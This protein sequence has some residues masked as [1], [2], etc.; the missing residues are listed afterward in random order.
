[1]KHGTQ[2]RFTKLKGVLVNNLLKEYNKQTKQEGDQVVY[3]H[4]VMEVEKILA[5]NTRL[6]EQQLQELQRNFA[7]GVMISEPNR[8]IH[9][10]SKRS[11]YNA[12][13][14]KSLAVS[15]SLGG[16]QRE[17]SASAVDMLKATDAKQSQGMQTERHDELHSQSHTLADSVA[18]PNM[19]IEGA[20]S[21]RQRR[22]DEWSILVLHSD[23]KHL[24]DQK[25]LKEKQF[26]DKKKTREE[27]Q[28]QML[29][30]VEAKKKQKA[31]VV[32]IAKMQ[33]ASYMQWKSE[34]ERVVQMKQAKIMVEKEY[35]AKELARVQKMKQADAE[36]NF[37]EQQVLF[38][39]SHACGA[40]TPVEPTT[41]VSAAVVVVSC[42]C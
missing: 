31:E 29:T 3:N 36:K 9:V 7:S 25:K 28:R 21:K 11:N 23:V 37:K 20:Q 10:A 38:F 17:K 16:E 12:K 5:H 24:E 42:C 18:E 2:D 30:N 32:E 8:N 35:E 15:R 26:I 13:A 34:Q 40:S 27:L 19:S 4:A 22:V 1:V 39:Y 14:A 41:V 33:E 6:T